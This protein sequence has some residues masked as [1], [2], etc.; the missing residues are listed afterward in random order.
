MFYVYFLK[1]SNNQVYTGFTADLKR[2]YDQHS[3]GNVASAKYKRPI[4]LIGYEAYLLKS[5]AQRRERY[6]KTTDGKHFFQQ[7]YRDLLEKCG[8]RNRRGAGV[9]DQASL[10]N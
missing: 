8:M 4:E 10:E 6:L 3:R 9:V 1:L 7:Q 5:D 2:R